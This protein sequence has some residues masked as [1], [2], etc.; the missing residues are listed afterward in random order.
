VILKEMWS[1]IVD[2][3]LFVGMEV[4]KSDFCEY[5]NEIKLSEKAENVSSG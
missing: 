2:F 4:V 3:S 1:E 5:D